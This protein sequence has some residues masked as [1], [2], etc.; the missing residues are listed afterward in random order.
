[1]ADGRTHRQLGT[2][3]AVVSGALLVAGCGASS[4]RSTG[5]AGQAIQRAAYVSSSTAGYRVA[6]SFKEGSTALGGDI[7]GTGTGSFNLPKHAGRMTLNLTLP[8]SLASAGTLTA[9][10]ILN[11]QTV[12]VKLPTQVSAQLPGGRPWIKIN[13]AA[14]GRAAG[15]QNLSSLFD[16]SGSTN[17]SDFLQYLR[18]TSS[19]RVK[20]LGTGSVDGYSATHYRATIDLTKA[21]SAAAPAER[22]NMRQAVATL[23]KLTGLRSIPVDVW[24]D[25]QHLVRRL[26]MAYTVHASGQSLGTQIRLDFLSYGPQP[27]PKAPPA[28]QVTDAGAMLAHL[29]G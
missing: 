13:L 2:L 20:K 21:A 12:Y 1:M 4:S 19:G 17:P 29:K 11:G 6:I 22:A 27:V 16:G 15:I 23:Q 10:E 5:S 3:A 14:V 28:G 7:T 9:Q 25:S 26:T 24:V 8:G 18:A